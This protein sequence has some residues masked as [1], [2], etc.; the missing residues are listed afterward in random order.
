M[1]GEASTVNAGPAPT[2]DKS[3]VWKTANFREVMM[4]LPIKPSPLARLLRWGAASTVNA[5]H[6]THGIHS[7]GRSEVPPDVGEQVASVP[8]HTWAD[9]A[10]VVVSMLGGAVQQIALAAISDPLSAFVVIWWFVETAHLVREAPALTREWKKRRKP[11]DKAKKP[12]R[13]KRGE[14]CEH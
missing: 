4:T 10:V 1:T 5:V 13:E 11:P 8:L 14:N 6:F 9:A 7:M 3:A 12:M 2:N